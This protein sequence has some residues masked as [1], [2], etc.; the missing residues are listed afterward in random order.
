MSRTKKMMVWI[1]AV[2]MMTAP[3]I[4]AGFMH[5]ED[6]QAWADGPGPQPP[7]PPDSGSSSQL[8]QLAIG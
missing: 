6:T 4:S 3:L 8:S 2:T 7:P 1:L 5:A